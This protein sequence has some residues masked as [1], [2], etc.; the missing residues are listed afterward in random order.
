MAEEKKVVIEG[1]SEHKRQIKH[2]FNKFIDFN[3]IKIDLQLSELFKNKILFT[4]VAVFSLCIVFLISLLYSFNSGF[5]FDCAGFL[6]YTEEIVTGNFTG[7]HLSN[8]T[9]NFLFTDFP[10]TA[11]MYLIFGFKDISIYLAGAA[12]YT[13][14]VFLAAW[15]AGTGKNTFHPLN[16]LVTLILF[17]VP[18]YVYSGYIVRNVMHISA[19]ILIMIFLL[20]T[21]YQDRFKSKRE[22]T[23]FW[24]CWFLIVFLSNFSDEL[25]LYLLTAPIIFSQIFIIFLGQK[26]S[27]PL[28]K[29]TIT[30][31]ACFLAREVNNFLLENECFVFYSNA[32]ALF[33][34]F[35]LIFDNILRYFRIIMEYF[36]SI[37]FGT[38]VISANTLIAVFGII[39]MFIAFFCIFVNVKEFKDNESDFIISVSILFFSFAYTFSSISK[40]YGLSENPRYLAPV[41]ICMCLLIGH[42][43]IRIIGII[44]KKAPSKTLFRDR[45]SII[46]TFGIVLFVAIKCVFSPLD[47]SFARPECPYNG[48]N[49]YALADILESK[50]LT[51]GYAPY[52]DSGVLQV[53]SEG[54]IKSHPVL[55]ENSGLVQN[56]WFTCDEWY[57]EYANFIYCRKGVEDVNEFTNMN[58]E[59]LTKILGKPYEILDLEQYTVWIWDYD[60][61]TRV[62]KRFAASKLSDSFTL[63]IQNLTFSPDCFFDQEKQIMVISSGSVQYGPYC[64]LS[65]GKYKVSVCG[66]NMS[67]AR[68]DAFSENGELPI[69]MIAI[70]KNRIEYFLTVSEDLECV[71][72]R[73]WN[74]SQENI[75]FECINVDK[76]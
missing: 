66:E 41:Y 69:E 27:D 73:T 13:L 51:C 28:V 53:V 56:S 59:K 47:L 57:D 34:D 26:R 19:M 44:E 70:D 18:C 48:L 8:A 16:F 52:S 42:N 1:L 4:V 3:L 49:A 29:I 6:K 12:E 50:G 64:K 72:F 20:L 23:V 21:S 45:F 58:T 40:S 67:S 14:L 71:E 74:D 2:S 5:D 43:F 17:T 63:T 54:K 38:E 9:S 22:K 37:L 46:V 75:Y 68:C 32:T 76:Q 31:V 15:F 25:T 55:A 24:I 60:I 61:S 10:I 30:I 62:K 36:G 11:L 33:V 65:K 35:D 7:K 39:L